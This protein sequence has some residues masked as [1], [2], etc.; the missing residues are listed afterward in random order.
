[1]ST[2]RALVLAVVVAG[3][4]YLASNGHAWWGWLVLVAAL[5]L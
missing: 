4:V 1:M 3:I 5:L 2:N